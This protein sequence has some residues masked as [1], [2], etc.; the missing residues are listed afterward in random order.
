MWADAEHFHIEAHLEAFD[1]EE[2][3]FSRDWQRK[4]PRDLV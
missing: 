1:G 2:R 4:I 3:V